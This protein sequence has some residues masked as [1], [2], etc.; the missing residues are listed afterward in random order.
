[1]TAKST[2]ISRKRTGIQGAWLVL[3]VFILAFGFGG[4]VAKTS[5]VDASMDASVEGAQS[6]EQKD[7][8]ECNLNELAGQGDEESV[9]GLL[10][11]EIPADAVEAKLTAIEEQVL[12]SEHEVVFQLDTRETKD[13]RR[14]FSYF[15]HDRKGRKNFEIWLKRSEKYMPYVR[16]V[17]EERGLPHDLVYLPFVE[18]GYNPKAGS[19]AG[20]K[21][22]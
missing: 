4:C 1:M 8:E 12:E 13:V 3:A 19:W 15:T 14:F 9:E 20:A 6:Q 7:S 11:D 22:M 17:F 2:Y 18:S 5:A 10:P 16:K 21:G